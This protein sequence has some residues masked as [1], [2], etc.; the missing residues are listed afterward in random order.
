M[1]SS[2]KRFPRSYIWIFGIAIIICL[3]WLVIKSQKTNLDW[4]TD[5]ISREIESQ[6]KLRDNF[7]IRLLAK[8]PD[9][10]NPMTMC[11]DK[12]GAIY[13]TESSTYRYGVEGAPLKDFL[14]PIKRIELDS[15]GKPTRV[16]VVAKG[17]ANPVM[18]VDIYEDKLYATCLNE[19]FVMD[20]GPEGQ[21]TNRQ[22]LVKDS[23]EPWNPFG[24]YRVVV[25]PDAKL[26]LAIADHPNS[27]PVT[28]TGSDGRRVR[29]RG[30]SGGFVRCNLDG[31]GLEIIVQGFRAPFAFDIDPWGH[32][33]AVSNGEGSPNIYVD[34]IPGMDYG[35]HSR[36]VSY[37]WL[38]G[39][40]TLAPPVNEMGPGANTIALHYYGSMFP[41]DFWGDIIMANW[42]SHGAHPTNR[43]LKQFLHPEKEKEGVS[44]T[45]QEG[46]R[47]SPELF[48]TS[49]DSMFRPVG[50]ITAPDGGLYLADW[51]GHDDESNNTGRIFKITYTG[52]KELKS[53][54]TP[55]PDKI[56]EMNPT[57][58][59]QLLG[60]E[61]RFIREQAQHALAQSGTDV[62]ESIGEVLKKENAFSAAN[63]IWTLTRINS[64]AAT[65]TMVIALSHPDSRVRAL[66]LRQLQQASAKQLGG[67]RY[68]AGI[69]TSGA[70]FKPSKILG[71][72]ELA[73]LAAPLVRDPNEEV[74]V[75]AAL[76]LNSSEAISGGLLTA[77][78][79]V[80]DKR[81][82]YQIGFELGKY[83][84]LAILEKLHT[85][86]NPVLKRVA[87]IAAETARNENNAL[88]TA[89]KDWDLILTD[90]NAAKELVAEIR[91]GRILP[92]NAG[93]R[94]VALE[95]LEAHPPAA[96]KSLSDFL[97][98]CVREN[99]YIVQAVALRILRQSTL[100]SPDTK[101]AIISILRK[102]KDQRS[103]RIQLEALYTLGSFADIGTSQEWLLWLKDSSKNVITGTLRALRQQKH[104]SEFMS[105]LW[106]TALSIAQRNPLLAEEIWNT[107]RQSIPDEQMER[108]PAR[109]VRSTDKN[110]FAQSILAGL[111]GASAQRGKWTFNIT[112][113][114]CHSVRSGDG[115]LR[116]GP[117]LA[118]IGAASQP[119]Y[120]IE[121]ILEPSKVLKTGFQIETIETKD[122]QVFNGQMETKDQQIIIKRIGTEPLK[123][124]MT[125]VRKRK[126]SHLSP[127][128]EGL[129]NEMT[130][131]EL[132][133]L[134]AYLLT[135]KESN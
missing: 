100:H 102:P 22:L 48:L 42:G 9:I 76:A 7:T 114:S 106:P 131:S 45:V 97:S 122:G 46:L 58:L 128:P 41:K 23:A 117:N 77:L 83:G 29:L 118:N 32:L 37:A 27:E 40:T 3:L 63:A 109:P 26:W 89:I 61:N 21:L 107:F 86:S 18:G 79:I 78:E 88:A 43:S 134:T 101:S 120:L 12:H 84:N 111:K 49:S 112:C 72:E 34:V 129:D 91:A 33:W 133:D 44:G 19:L 104:S 75:E 82:L 116:L 108:L 55:S 92:T 17:F 80:K 31:S 81:L 132:A 53:Q 30:Q 38:A 4:T 11:V 68:P 110:Q 25:G 74:R 13:V 5:P 54:N 113:A 51:H 98:N 69:G 67:M 96:S 24:M 16:T 20:I 8:E 28:L 2:T 57:E 90:E 56:K 87:L 130:V 62:V 121:S 119:Q 65:H 59:C 47:E 95:W 94:L 52:K 70:E 14:N 135:L 115:E 66:G 73:K 39:K 15:K 35:Y 10:M 99:D 105:A 64:V 50:M 126:T 124:P 36:N 71:A 127:M 123:V 93:D 6:F 103:V 85:A 60:N 125:N 1:I